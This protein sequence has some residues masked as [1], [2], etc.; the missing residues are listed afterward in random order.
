PDVEYP[1]IVETKDGYVNH[2]AGFLFR[3]PRFECFFCDS[4]AVERH[5]LIVG[6][7]ALLVCR[8][9][10]ADTGNQQ[11]IAALRKIGAEKS[12][13]F[14]PSARAR[15]FQT[16]SGSA[17]HFVIDKFEIVAPAHITCEKLIE[18]GASHQLASL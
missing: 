6:V 7:Q 12:F 14:R 18:A 3:K 2:V 13:S 1:Q 8:R 10:R 4:R 11:T 5:D 17:E 16:Q 15:C 9:T